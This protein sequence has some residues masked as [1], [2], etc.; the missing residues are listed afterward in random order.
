MSPTATPKP[1]NPD[2]PGCGIL[3]R[4][5]VLSVLA[6]AIVGIV[7]GVLLSYAEFQNK[8]AVLRWLGLVG[9]LFVSLQQLSSPLCVLSN[10]L[11]YNHDRS[12]LFK[13]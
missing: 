8:S 9:D 6:F 3:A 11:S 2:A 12:V 4:C 10:S 1:S 13:L 7:L 5:P